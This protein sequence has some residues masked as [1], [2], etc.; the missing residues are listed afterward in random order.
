MSNNAEGVYKRGIVLGLVIGWGNL[1]GVVSSN[2]FFKPPQYT[3]GHSV[4]IA[5]M[6]ACL[7]G[8]SGL[9]HFLLERENAA[10]RA[11]K[12]DHLAEGKTEKEIEAL[13]DNRPDFFYTT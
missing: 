3:V 9:M 1:N 5:Y 13:G 7:V 8:G 10:R 11:G 2:I 6:V 12:R 4:I